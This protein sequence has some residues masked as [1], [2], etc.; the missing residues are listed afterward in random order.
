MTFTVIPDR[1]DERLCILVSIS[2]H[3]FG[4]LSQASAVI[5]ALAKVSRSFGLIVRS[6]LPKSVLEAWLVVPF[7]YEVAEDDVGM[8]MKNALSVDWEASYQAYSDLHANWDTKVS[9]LAHHFRDLNVSLVI[10]DVAYLP[11]AAAEY[12][13][14][15]SVGLCSLNWADILSHYFPGQ[16]QWIATASQ[17][18]DS[19]RLFI[20]PEPSMDM[21]WL[22]G[23]FN[24]GPIGRVGR[25]CREQVD[26][27]IGAG[28]NSYVVLTSMGGIGQSLDISRWPMELGG[29]RVH[30]LVPDSWCRVGPNFSAFSDFGLSFENLMASCDLVITKPGYGMFVEA[31]GVGVPV[32]F[33]KRD[34]WPDVTSLT[35]WL[36]SVGVAEEISLQQLE[37]D[38]VRGAMERLLLRGRYSPVALDGGEESARILA[39]L[40]Q[41]F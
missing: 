26:G 4:H 31:A 1:P 21:G 5:N 41:E 40:L 27:V 36:K 6:S 15:P 35:V 14:I 20:A 25:C 17:A 16:K 8:R 11:L 30:Y 3:G 33:A 19:A 23:R 29:K 10:T 28:N 12:A 7:E 39:D 24:V 38:R 22:G 32:L 2:G 37:S 9:A 13:G 34:G 18:Y